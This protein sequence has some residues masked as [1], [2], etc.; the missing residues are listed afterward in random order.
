MAD[1]SIIIDSLDTDFTTETVYRGTASADG[2][3]DE[4]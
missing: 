1:G 3:T 2:R 4:T